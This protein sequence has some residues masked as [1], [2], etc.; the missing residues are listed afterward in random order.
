MCSP[1]LPP[2]VEAELPPLE[3][4]FHDQEVEMQDVH[5]R[6][7][8]TIKRLG[9][10]LHRVNMTTRYGKARANSPCDDDHKLGPLL[11]YFVM[12]ENTGVTVAN[13]IGRVLAENVDALE[14]LLVKSKKLLKEASKT[15]AKLLTHLAKQKLALEKSH[16]TQVAWVEATRELNQIT[17]QLDRIRDTVTKHTADIA[18]IE[19]LLKDCES[20]DEESS[21]SGD[22]SPP[23]PESGDP[24]A[25]TPQ[26]W[27][28][29]EQDVE[30]RDEEADSNLLQGMATQTDPPPKATEGD[31]ESEDDDVI[32]EDERF[33]VEGGG[34]TPITPVDDRLLDDQKE[35]TGAETPS[36]VVA[37]LLSQINMDS[38]TS[39][40]VV[41][42]PPS[43]I[44]ETREEP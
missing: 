15:Q 38:P 27:E 19:A 17:E 8:A 30:M 26:G 16:S 32:V 40:P 36:R 41:S 9:A 39:T 44:K 6:C 42:D 20:K 28:E 1:V 2:V 10:W 33:I 12:P 14:M 29:E 18:H 3:S 4:Y 11:D 43:D 22:S 25:A 35:A 37:E 13:I 5:I 7:L 34:A 21:S 23:D 31:P 24:P